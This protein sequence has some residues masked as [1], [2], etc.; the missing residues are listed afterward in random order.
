MRPPHRGTELRP[1]AETL[2]TAA[3]TACYSVGMTIRA[4]QHEALRMLA[5]S[6]GGCTVS[7]MMA[8]GCAIGMLD[9]LVRNGFATAHR[10]N[11]G[12][13]RGVIAVTRLRITDA[14]RR[15]LAE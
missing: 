3:R 2:T 8:H 12:A 9:D 7:I 1:G 15:A 11:M 14:G 6:P 10:E 5:G 4:D 13:G